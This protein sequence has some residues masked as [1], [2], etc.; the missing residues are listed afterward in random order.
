MARTGR[1]PKPTELHIR[2]GTLGTRQRAKT[3]LIIGGRRKPSCPKELTGHAK[4]AFRLLVGDLWD[5]GILDA[6]DR[7]MIITAAMHYGVAMCAQEKIDRVGVAYPVKRGA[8]ENQYV[9]L[10]ANPAVKM[11]RDSLME[12]RHCCDILGIGPTA[13]AR[14]AGMGVKSKTVEKDVPGLGQLRVLRD[15]TSK[16]VKPPSPFFGGPPVGD[17]GDKK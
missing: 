13:R 2:D 5:S 3:P 7:T 8:G 11:Q 4:K 17:S 9:S 14:L 1:P 15:G 10:E 12:Y 6:A 16:I